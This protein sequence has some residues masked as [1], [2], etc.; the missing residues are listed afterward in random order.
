MEALKLTTANRNVLS[1]YSEKDIPDMEEVSDF[2]RANLLDKDIGA[3]LDKIV[4]GVDFTKIGF[5]DKY[6]K[7]EKDKE[8]KKLSEVEIDRYVKLQQ[9]LDEVNNELERNA[10]LYELAATDEERLVYLKKETDLL[11]NKKIALEN[12]A[13]ELKKERAERVKD[14]ESF[15]VKFE[16]QDETL[17]MTNI[18]EI[19]ATERDKVNKLA[20]SGNDDLYEKEVEKFNKLDT[21]YKRFLDIQSQEIPEKLNEIFTGSIREIEIGDEI[22]N[23]E[24]SNFNELADQLRKRLE[25]FNQEL[26]KLNSEM[27][28]TET[29]DYAEKERILGEIYRVTADKASVLKRNIEELLDVEVISD[30]AISAVNE[31]LNDTT[32]ELDDSTYALKENTKAKEDNNEA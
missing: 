5:S 18:D 22:S 1:L 20:K 25:P 6:L 23:I 30:D 26:E 24:L 29:E 8:T 21:L 31:T 7:G 32:K 15:G 4:S 27:S 17:K 14:L 16:G 13:I 12:I 2:I 28:L 3:A 9:A 11:K 19:L 10:K